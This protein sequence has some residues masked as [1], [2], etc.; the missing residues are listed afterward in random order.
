M[1]SIVKTFIIEA[2]NHCLGKFALFGQKPLYAT[3][4]TAPITAKH[5]LAP[6]LTLTP[7]P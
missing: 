5:R 3:Q 1:V 4:T 6:V 2:E 7:D